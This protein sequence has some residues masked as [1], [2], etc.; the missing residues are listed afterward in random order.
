MKTYLMA[1]LCLGIASTL[2]AQE[3]ELS[4][5]LRPRFEYRHGYKTLIPDDVDAA[6]FVSQRT[7]F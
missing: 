4:T 1:I 5:E 3:L 6:M 7:R 2:Y